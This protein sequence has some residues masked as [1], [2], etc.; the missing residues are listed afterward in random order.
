MPL[1]EYQC[2]KGHH[3]EVQ[4]SMSAAPLERCNE[5]GCR[6][7]AQR[8][9]SRSGF[10][11]AGSGWY[12]DGYGPKKSNGTADGSAC[13]SSCACDATKGAKNDAKKTPA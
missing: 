1:Y 9:I 3:F 4:Q 6:A 13:G 2:T 8:L 11:L 5:P 12:A 10:A 7:R